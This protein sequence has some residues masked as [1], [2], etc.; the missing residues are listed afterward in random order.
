MCF[1]CCFN[2]CSPICI[3]VTGFIHNLIAISFL[4][5][6]LVEVYLRKGEK[7]LYVIGFVLLNISLLSFIGIFIILGLRN[8]SNYLSLDKIGKILSLIIIICCSIAPILY[9]LAEIFIIKNYADIDNFFDDYGNFH[10][11]TDEWCAA[12]IPGLIAII[13]SAIIECPASALFKIFNE[14]IF[15][16]TT[17]APANPITLNQNSITTVPVQNSTNPV[18]ISETNAGILPQ[19]NIN[20]PSSYQSGMAINNGK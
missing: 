3:T 9:I 16:T 8:T 11:P 17:S 2:S 6:G 19:L 10:I 5:W 18:P 15:T 7:A 20:P 12:I 4:I 14:N 1:C 13:T